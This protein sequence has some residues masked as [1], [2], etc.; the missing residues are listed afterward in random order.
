MLPSSPFQP[1]Q[2]M[3]TLMFFFFFFFFFVTSECKLGGR[4]RRWA[5]TSWRALH[6]RQRLLCTRW[7]WLTWPSGQRSVVPN[8]LLAF[9][10]HVLYL[11]SQSQSNTHSLPL[12]HTHTHTLSLSLSLYP[13]VVVAAPVQGS[14]GDGCALQERKGRRGKSC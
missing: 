8:V 1:Q 11:K 3:H 13:S 4:L 2:R 5:P 10:R 7:Q 14:D 9:D 6:T 12:A